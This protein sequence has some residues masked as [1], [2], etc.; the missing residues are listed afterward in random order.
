MLRLSIISMAAGMMPRPMMPETVALAS[1]IVSKTSSM[2]FTAS[3]RFSSRTTI[4]VTIPKVPS[5][6]TNTPVRS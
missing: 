3:G 2:V 5:E 6:P 1:A 4:L